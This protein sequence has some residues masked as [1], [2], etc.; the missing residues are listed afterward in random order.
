MD[1]FQFAKQGKFLMLA[2]D[3]RESFK[4][5]LNQKAPQKVTNEEIITTKKEILEILADEFSGFLI[6]PEFGLKAYEQM[7][8]KPKTPFLLSIEKSGYQEK[9]EERITYLQYNVSQLKQMGAAG[10]KLLVYFN[11]YVSTSIYQLKTAGEVFKQCQR[12]NLPFFL[13]IVTYYTE[14]T[15]NKK[16]NLVIESL[17]K[18]LGFGIRANVFKL[19]YPKNSASCKQISQILGKTPWILL[20]RGENFNIFKL[21]LEDAVLNGASGFLAGRSLWQ[22]IGQFQNEKQRKEFL[23]STVKKRFQEIKNIVEKASFL[24]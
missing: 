10:V 23:K 13:E 8:E 12:E 15:L 14:S 3:H 24:A 21:Q 6:D 2:L 4:K 7:K 22:E 9:N 19:E 20:S 18:F 1:A 16:G 17:L 5:V 11:P